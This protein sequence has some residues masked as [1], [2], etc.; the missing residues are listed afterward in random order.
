MIY[1]ATYLRESPADPWPLDHGDDP[2]FGSSWRLG[3][4]TRQNGTGLVVSD[5]LTPSVR[6]RLVEEGLNYLDL[7]GNVRLILVRPGLF[8]ET[9]GATTDPN[10]VKQGRRSLR[11]AKAGRIVRVLCDFPPPLPISDLAG[12]AD[13]DISYA[14]RL[15]DWLAQED[16]V[17][18]ASR[19]PVETVDRARMIRRW[20][21]DYSSP[22]EQRG[23]VFP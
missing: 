13:V 3:L 16:L 19:G 1:V 7:T 17:T 22:E 12:K 5:F 21:D 23:A 15:V 18:R 14:S 10:P 4:D 2:S 6:R 8:V 9:D 11:G 20:A